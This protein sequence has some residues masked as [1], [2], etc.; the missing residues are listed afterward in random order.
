MDRNPLGKVSERCCRSHWGA[1]GGGPIA[2]AI[3]IA[4]A[5]VEA[6]AKY[7]SSS[8]NFLTGFA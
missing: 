6:I 1:A 3:A 8:G 7:L 5:Q 4:I 2:I